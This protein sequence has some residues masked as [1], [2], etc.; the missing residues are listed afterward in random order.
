MNDCDPLAWIWSIERIE[1]EHSTASQ[2][3]ATL[4]QFPAF[5]DKWFRWHFRSL[6]VPDMFSQYLCD[7]CHW[8]SYIR[9]SHPGHPRK[10]FSLTRNE[11]D[12]IIYSPSCHSKGICCPHLSFSYSKKSFTESFAIY[13]LMIFLFY[14]FVFCLVILQVGTWKILW[15]WRTQLMWSSLTENSRNQH[16]NLLSLMWWEMLLYV[17][18]PPGFELQ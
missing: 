14:F 7:S 18:F 4:V 17:Y 1:K 6:T 9:K 12:I 2:W 13:F 8:T 3:N 5:L 16:Q 11:N 15:G 10:G